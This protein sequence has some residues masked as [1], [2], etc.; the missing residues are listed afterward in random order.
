VFVNPEDTWQTLSE[1]IKS[2]L[3]IQDEFEMAR[4]DNV[5]IPIN[6]NQ[7]QQQLNM[8]FKNTQK[9]KLVLL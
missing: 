2:E 7:Y 8:H 3:G 9:W 5:A 4:W 1:Q 6:R